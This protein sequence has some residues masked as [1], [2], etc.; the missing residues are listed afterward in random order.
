VFSS[1]RTRRLASDAY[2]LGHKMTALVREAT[3][4]R[5]VLHCLFDLADARRQHVCSPIRMLFSA[6][7]Q[8]LT[9]AEWLGRAPWLVSIADSDDDQQRLSRGWFCICLRNKSCCKRRV[10]KRSLKLCHWLPGQIQTGASRWGMQKW[11]VRRLPCFLACTFNYRRA[12]YT[13]FA[14]V[15]DAYSTRV[16]NSK[17]G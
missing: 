14:N 12:C 11:P 6:V 2:E 13:L 17:S 9:S 8:W 10:G 4:T 3:S 16:V 7:Q 5:V 1:E 15:S